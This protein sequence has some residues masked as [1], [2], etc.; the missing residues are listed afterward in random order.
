MTHVAGVHLV[1]GETVEPTAGTSTS[2]CE[3]ESGIGSVMFMLGASQVVV[4]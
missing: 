1:A 4:N 3:G 2:E